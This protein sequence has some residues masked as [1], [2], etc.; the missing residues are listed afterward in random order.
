LLLSIFTVCILLVGINFPRAFADSTYTVTV[1]VQGLPAN[2]VADLYVN[3]IYNG[4]LA[5]GASVTYTL[6]SANSPYFI[7]VDSYVQGSNNGTR[8][9]CQNAAWQASVSATQ[10]FTYVTEYFLTVQSAYSSATGQGWYTSGSA[11]RA[12]VSGQE[13]PE[14][15][16]TRNIF[17]GWSADAT[18]TQLTSNAITM[19]GPKIAIANWKTQ[20]FLTVQSDPANVTGLNGSDWYDA[21]AQANFSAAMT[22]T[23]TSNTRLKFDHWS[24]E[25]SGQQPVGSVSMDRPKTVVANYL[26]QYLLAVGYSPAEVAGSYNETHAGWYDTNSDVQLGPAPAIINVSTVE[27]LQFTA[28]SDDGSVSNNLSYTVLVDRPRN[29]TLSYTAQYYLDIRSTYGTVS[30]SGWYSRGSTVT[31]SA[32][33]SSG[34][35]PISYTLTGWTV[36]PPT[37]ALTNKGGSW[38]IVVDR[39]YVVQAQWSIDYF[40]LIMLFGGTA[41]AITTLSVGAVVGYKRGIFSRR[42]HTP[43]PQKT[44]QTLTIPGAVVVCSHCGNDVPKGLEFCDKCGASIAA[45]QITSQDDKVYDYIVNH[46]GVISLRAASTDLGISVEQLK[47]ITERLKREGRLS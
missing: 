27:R 19:N 17:G 12:T 11:A 6:S 9:Y 28:W 30:G 21:G 18:G 5:G 42:R 33:T 31:I 45:I 10:V 4:T 36:D 39:P 25:F 23:V 32:P 8:Y 3:G 35:W 22:I 2:L 47:V 38:A 14:G 1:T 41:V 20:F 15:Q 34:T 29:V 26:A 7:S 46:Q 40:P 37:E 24:D 13:V 16:D 44:E 43:L